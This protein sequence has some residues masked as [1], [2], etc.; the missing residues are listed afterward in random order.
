M[1]ARS[2]LS[3][4]KILHDRKM[5]AIFRIPCVFEID[6]LK[7]KDFRIMVEVT[8]RRI[9]KRVVYEVSS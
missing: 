7:L 1:Y 6:R 5:L 3:L 4:Q 8:K 9:I 2:A